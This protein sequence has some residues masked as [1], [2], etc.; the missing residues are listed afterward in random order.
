MAIDAGRNTVIDFPP[1]PAPRAVPAAQPTAARPAES[2]L[3]RALVTQGL[4]EMFAALH[5]A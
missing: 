3:I 2:E 1:P 5:A 4:L